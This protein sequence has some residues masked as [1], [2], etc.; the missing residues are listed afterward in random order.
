MNGTAACLVDEAF[1]LAFDRRGRPR[2]P[3][4]AG[5]LLVCPGGLAGTWQGHRC[6][7]VSVDGLWCWEHPAVAADEIRSSTG[8]ARLLQSVTVIDPAAVTLVEAVKSRCDWG[9]HRLL[10]TTAFRIAGQQLHVDP[11][12]RRT[13]VDQ[14]RLTTA[15]DRRP[16]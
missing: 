14:G 4:L 12:L 9:V 15:E 10:E 8:P 6:R 5:E 11:Q 7:F 13:R 1:N 2:L 16:M 3:Y